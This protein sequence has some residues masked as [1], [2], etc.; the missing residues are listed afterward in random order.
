MGD[1]DITIK[2]GQTGQGQAPKRPEAPQSQREPGKPS[3]Q[4]QAV[5]N[6]LISAGRQILTQGVDQYAQMS[7]NY[8]AAERFN[9]ALSITSD[10]MM[11]STGPVGWIAVGTKHAVS[12]ANSFISQQNARDE[13]R[14]Q[15]ERAGFITT[16]GSRYER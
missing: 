15:R 14:M 7:G 11:L 9:N 8:V 3:I 12:I 4:N 5:N 10:M 16:Q 2:K 1:I 13:I 6:A